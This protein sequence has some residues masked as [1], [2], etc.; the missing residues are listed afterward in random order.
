[1]AR[2]QETLR[3]ITAEL[4]GGDLSSILDVPRRTADRWLAELRQGDADNW[5]A[6]AIEALARYE[7]RIWGTTRI[8]DALKPEQDGH[9]H[10]DRAD[11][12]RLVHC[13]QT[14]IASHESSTSL[15]REIVDSI[16]DN[17]LSA[18]EAR[19]LLDLAGTALTTTAAK[20]QT[21]VRMQAQLINF[22]RSGLG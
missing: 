11:V 3:T 10:G 19:R 7:S 14:I 4:S 21:L 2:L 18:D 9:G 12:H 22:L 13:L 6:A 5:N 20:H 17:Q 16:S 8:A 1:M 15:I